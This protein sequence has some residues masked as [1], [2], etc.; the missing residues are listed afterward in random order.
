MHSALFS[1][2]YIKRGGRE[3]AI[4][5]SIRTYTYMQLRV[6]VER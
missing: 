2:A 6:C 4:Y 1:V 3:K 5:P